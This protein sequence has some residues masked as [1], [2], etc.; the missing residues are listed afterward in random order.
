MSF[1]D[2]KGITVASGFKLQA[3]SLLDVRGCVETIAER[4][5]LV[6]LHAVTEGLKVY[7][8]SN[9]TLYVW[10]GGSWDEL[11]K[12]SGYVHPDE[13]GYKHIPAGGTPGQVLKNQAPG[14]A[15][16]EDEKNYDNELAGKV[17]TSRKINNKP[18]SAD[19][20]LGAEDVGAVPASQK[21]AAGG[22]AELDSTGKVPTSQLPSYVDDVI[23]GYLS[24]GKF[25]KEEAHTTQITGESGKI[26]VD[27]ATNKTYRW[28]GTTF[29]EISASLALGETASTAFRGDH[30]KAAYTH[31]Q[32]AHAPANAEANVQS[33]WNATDTNSDA[34]IKNK[35]TS[36][37]ANGGNA[38]TV[39]GHTVAVDVPANAKFTDTVYQHPSTHAAS[40]IT[41]DATHRF[42]SDD[43]KE[44]WNNKPEI[45]FADALPETAPA[46]SIC[47]ITE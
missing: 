6:T 46:G 43:E 3:A 20:A 26:Y 33:D 39:G 32:A 18:L 8:K 13:P 27:L 4:D 22:V 10:N 19:V 40:M 34:F 28:S 36:M 47:F 2:K 16:W 17:P 14:E 30:G 12:G 5:E 24:G 31:S 11:S 21:G 35:P 7:V 25:Y 37:P 15:V 41:E 38:D 45:Y 44:K 23:E 29:S 42:V 1:T 9:K